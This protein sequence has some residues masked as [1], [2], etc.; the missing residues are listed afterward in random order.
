MA[1]SLGAD[2]PFR[3]RGYYYDA[4]TGLYYLNSRYYNPEWGRFIS[5]DNY[6]GATG[7]LLSHNMFAYC[8][9]NPVMASDPSGNLPSVHIMMTDSGSGIIGSYP[10]SNCYGTAT[11]QHSD[12][13]PGGADYKD[14][15]QYRIDYYQEH[16]KY[17]IMF[18]YLDFLVGLVKGEGYT[19]LGTGE[20][21]LKAPIGANEYRMAMRISMRTGAYHVMRTYT[22]A[23]D[24]WIQQYGWKK[25]IA[26]FEGETPEDDWSSSGYWDSPTIYFAVPCK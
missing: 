12:V 22:T 1:A 17:P 11:N 26:I 25:E 16:N 8:A 3:Y 10:A 5:A 24:I 15:A 7:E 14:W 23:S 9:N 18:E 13:D 19:C 4:E 6:G 20:K 2:N 21:G